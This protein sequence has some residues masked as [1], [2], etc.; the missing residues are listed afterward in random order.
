[1]TEQK[2]NGNGLWKLLAVSVIGL[3]LGMVADAM[4]QPSD[5]V[6]ER[7][8]E[9]RLM[10]VDQKLEAQDNRL[11]TISNQLAAIQATQNQQN[12][13]LARVAAKVGVTASPVVAP[14]APSK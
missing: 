6:R 9:L 13:D 5:T 14:V 7:E 8:L 3:L 2:S 11:V 4:R 1:M 10:V 12:S